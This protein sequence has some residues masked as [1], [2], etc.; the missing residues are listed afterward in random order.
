MSGKGSKPRPYSVSQ[1][2]FASNWDNIFKKKGSL[3][4]M[5]QSEAFLFSVHDKC[6]TD[7]CC[8]TCDTAENPPEKG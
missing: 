5:M 6:G 2:Q 3:K 8:N 4:D 7:D 1:T